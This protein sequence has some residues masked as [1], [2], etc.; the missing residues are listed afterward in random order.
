MVITPRW[1]SGSRVAYMGFV[2]ILKSLKNGSYY[3]GSTGNLER[4]IVEHNSG[5]T[6]SLKYL[7]PFQ[8]VFSQSFKNLIIAKKVEL[9]LKKFK[10]KKILEQI[11]KDQK[12][13]IIE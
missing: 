6:K 9:R 4:R 2:Y 1:S 8:L 7:I 13:R 12:L 11:I 3:V 5:K 10:S